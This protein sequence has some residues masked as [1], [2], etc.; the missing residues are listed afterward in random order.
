MDLLLGEDE[1]NPKNRLVLICKKCRLVNGQ[2]PPG[3][4]TLEDVGKWRCSECGTMNG[5]ESEAKKLVAEI[6]QRVVPENKALSSGPVI[7]PS[8]EEEVVLVGHDGEQESDHTVYSDELP[9]EN[10]RAIRV[11]PEPDKPKRG[12]PKGSSKK[13]S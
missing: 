5:E 1:T 7:S 11:E 13:K 10:N 8:D 6:Q 12:R 9:E 4:K 3:V 2:A